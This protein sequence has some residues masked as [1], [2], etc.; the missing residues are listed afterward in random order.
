MATSWFEFIS[1]LFM[2][3][4]VVGVV[5]GGIYAF[6]TISATIEQTRNDLRSKGVNISDSGVQIK[7]NKHY[8]HEDYIDAT[9]R[10]LTAGMDPMAKASSFKRVNP[11]AGKEKRRKP[12]S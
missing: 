8:N 11:E 3:F 10:V 9:Q 6:R 2:T 1:S 4:L 7:T 5:V 12:T